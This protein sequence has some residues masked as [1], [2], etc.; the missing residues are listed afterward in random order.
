[1]AAADKL[2]HLVDDRFVGGDGLKAA[3]VAAVAAFAEWLDLD[4]ADLADVAVLAEEHLTLGDDPG[5]GALVDAHQNR[6]HAV[7]GLAEEV[8]GQRQRAGVVA[9]IAGEVKVVLKQLGQSQIADLVL[10]GIDDH[11]GFRIDQTRHGEGDADEIAAAL[12]VGVDEGANFPQQHVDHGLLV[13]LGHLNDVLVELLAVEII[14]TQLQI[15]TAQLGGDKLKAMLDGG[16]RDGSPPA[17]GGL[18]RGLLDQTM[19]DQLPGYFGHA[20]RGQLTQ[21]GNFDPRDGALQ[22]D[23]P[24]Y[25]CTVD[26]LDKIYVCYLSA[27]HDVTVVCSV[28]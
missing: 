27:S 28:R 9:H 3:K 24:I 18:R 7:A 15:A 14:E 26:L 20:G 22:V 8:F 5:A 1:M 16:Q 13:D 19:L 25:G 21:L 11:A 12:G 10:G 4:M 23:E 2:L 6:V 17:G